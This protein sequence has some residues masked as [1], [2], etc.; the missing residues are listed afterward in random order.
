MPNSTCAALSGNSSVRFWTAKMELFYNGHVY[1]RMPK[2]HTLSDRFHI[3][4]ELQTE[5]ESHDRHSAR[6][7]QR[8][9]WG[10]CREWDNRWTS[11]ILPVGTFSCV[12]N[13]RT[14]TPTGMAQF[15]GGLL[16]TTTLCFTT[17]CCY[18]PLT[19]TVTCTASGIFQTAY[20][21]GL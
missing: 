11:G 16:L 13:G 5:R 2:G 12:R 3:C 6:R 4:E 1:V 18:P 21:I 17:T 8:K 15:P 19:H 14:E 20:K 10:P 9:A 7:S